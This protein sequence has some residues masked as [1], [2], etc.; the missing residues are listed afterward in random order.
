MKNEY[1]KGYIDAINSILAKIEPPE[2]WK[3]TMKLHSGND[4][5]CTLCGF[6]PDA[7]IKILKEIKKYHL[8]IEVLENP[9]LG[10][11]PKLIGQEVHYE[12]PVKMPETTQT[13]PH[14]K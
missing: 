3:Q 5:M 13:T 14:N 10:D 1:S 6:R 9:K 2:L 8:N 7:L 11:A 4:Q 12:T